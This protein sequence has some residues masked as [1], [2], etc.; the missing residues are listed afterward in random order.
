MAYDRA[1]VGITTGHRVDLQAVSTS[2]LGVQ[3]QVGCHPGEPKRLLFRLSQ[4]AR[5]PLVVMF[6]EIGGLPST[7]LLVRNSASQEATEAWDIFHDCLMCYL[8]TRLT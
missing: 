2:G 7:L 1:L 5:C 3:G 8:E 6:W 4:G